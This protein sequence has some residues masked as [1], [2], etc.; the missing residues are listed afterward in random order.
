MKRL[1]SQLLWVQAVSQPD[2]IDTLMIARC[3]QLEWVRGDMIRCSL[4]ISI[5]N[6][7]CPDVPVRG[8]EGWST[9]FAIPGASHSVLGPSVSRPTSSYYCCMVQIRTMYSEP[10]STHAHDNA[11]YSVSRGI[12][13]RIQWS[14][15]DRPEQGKRPRPLVTMTR[16]RPERV[17]CQGASSQEEPSP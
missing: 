2:M 17:I 16:Q 6:P 8:L 9:Y 1:K 3:I 14:K 15:A 7:R 11:L 12:F 5:G 4:V 13:A 10:I